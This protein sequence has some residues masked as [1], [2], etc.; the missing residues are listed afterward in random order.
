[1]QKAK[2]QNKAKKSQ[3]MDWTTFYGTVAILL[4]AVIPMMAFPKASQKVI[5]DINEAVS[6]SLGAVYL[7]LGLIVLGFV[8]YID[9]ANT[10]T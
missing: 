4:I 5:T 2:K 1:M 3:I 8:L 9:L 7:S 10:E 6:N